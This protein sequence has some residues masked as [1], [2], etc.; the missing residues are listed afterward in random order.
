MQ[1]HGARI[2]IVDDEDGI[3]DLFRVTLEA[4]GCVCHTAS[5]GEAALEVLAREPFDLALVDITMPRMS[6]LALFQ[7]MRD[8]HSSVSVVFITA[9]DELTLAVEH[10]KQGAYDYIVKPVAKARL[11]GVVEG[12]LGRRQC[13]LQDEQH[14]RSL[15]EQT[16][17]Q[18]TQL[19]ARMRELSSLNRMFQAELSNKF[20]EDS[21]S[22]KSAIA[23]TLGNALLHVGGRGPSATVPVLPGHLIQD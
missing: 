22:P 16:A 2:L 6:G 10:L 4:E 19:E 12:A 21:T 17:Q 3:R 14:R 8:G 5:D 11:L 7:H 15:E 13:A 9:V 20:S 1:L 18:A 23:S